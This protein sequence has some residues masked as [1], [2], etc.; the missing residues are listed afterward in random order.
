MLQNNFCY[1]E[2]SDADLLYQLCS[3]SL[4]HQTDFAFA[5]NNVRSL[6]LAPNKNDFVL[7]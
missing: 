4:T 6:C 3:K 5:V 1:V 2:T 7:S